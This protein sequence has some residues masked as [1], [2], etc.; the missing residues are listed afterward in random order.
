MVEVEFFEQP[1]AN[2]GEDV[3]ICG[4]C[5][6]L[7]AIPFSYTQ[8]ND[9]DEN[10]AQYWE[11]LY[12]GKCQ[13]LF[14]MNDPNT[15]VCLPEGNTDAG[16]PCGT[17]YGDY[18]F[19]WHEIN[20]TCQSTDT[21]TIS[22]GKMPDPGLLCG[23]CYEGGPIGPPN[24][25][26]G[27]Y[28]CHLV[29]DTIVV[30]A[31]ECCNFSYYPACDPYTFGNDG[32]YWDWSVIGPAGTTFDPFPGYWDADGNFHWPSI[33]VCWG[34]CC[35]TGYIYVTEHTPLCDTTFEWVFIINQAPAPMIVGPEIAEVTTDDITF[36][37][38]AIIDPETIHPMDTTCWLYEWNVQPCGEI[39]SGQGT[40]CINVH[41]FAMGWGTV[42]LVV[43]D[44]CT[45][46]SGRDTLAVHVLPQY[47][48]GDCALSGYVNY[49]NAS[50][51]PLDGVHITLW[52]GTV[53]IFDTW[54]FNDIDGGNGQGYYEFPGINCTNNFGLTADYNAPWWMPGP[55]PGANATDALA[56]QLF[57]IGG[58][59]L[60][61]H[62]AALENKAADVNLSSTINA[63]DA[64]WV[65]Q[66]AINMVNHFPAGDWAFGDD[67][68]VLMNTTAGTFNILA[69]T[70]GDVNRSNIPATTK[71]MPAVDLINDG[72]ISVVPGEVFELPIRVAQPVT[73]GAITLNLGYNTSLL[74]VIDVTSADGMVNNVDGNS[75]YIAWS[76]VNPMTLNDNDAVVTLRMKAKGEIVGGEE[77]L[78]VN[79][80]TEFAD[81]N[82]NVIQGMTLKT[83][84][85]TTAPAPD[86]YFLSD[87]RP[88]PFSG[89]TQIDYT[90][91][92]KGKVRL[93]VIDML[94]QEI[95]VLVESTQTAGSYTIT[96]GA[97][98]MTPGV[99]MYKIVVQGETKNFVESRRMIVS[100]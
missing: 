93:S 24:R 90:L 38:C 12:N 89:T 60:G 63:T 81:P 82:A 79:F 96:Y 46:C 74:D 27:Q 6:Q 11:Y 65:K 69:L 56:I 49:H 13:P 55:L 51:T 21:V 19:V 48:L 76:S 45:G 2:A 5:A 32:R 78:T 50:G 22:F 85:I 86:S 8:P 62:W 61:F 80:G 92:E 15:F 91:P 40:S 37:Y 67:V 54:S 87:C 98:G 9:V 84:G 3:E 29:N 88:N 43:F 30:C 35:D 70:Y 83:F 18:S 1:T 16:D 58:L 39:V 77:L 7:M 68:N 59:P 34:E 73:L 94:G 71:D 57:T 100:H 75:I 44:T 31:F 23:Q 25:G 66:R 72:V 20:G 14:T 36:S 41:W 99:Y 17:C 52:N 33:N 42:E 97:P 64:L 28:D 53:P 47:S 26:D 4:N 10:F 95:A